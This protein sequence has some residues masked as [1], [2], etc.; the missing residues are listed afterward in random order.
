MQQ[1]DPKLV[2]AISD[3]LRNNSFNRIVEDAKKCGF[4]SQP[5]TVKVSYDG[6]TVRSERILMR[7]KSRRE[8][9][10]SS[11][12]SL[13]KGDA[14]RLIVQGLTESDGVTGTRGG[15]LFFTLTAPSFGAVHSSSGCGPE[16]G[17]SL[18]KPVQCRH[19]NWSICKTNHDENDDAI[20]QPLCYEC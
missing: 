9:L 19:G 13:Y 2:T 8:M 4:C 12:S 5:I 14:R 11:C 20:G 1:N 17:R 15:K 3:S 10:C 7:C 6:P 18:R 16:N